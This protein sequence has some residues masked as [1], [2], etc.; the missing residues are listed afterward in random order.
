MANIPIHLQSL[1][2][3]VM[4]DLG[5]LHYNK[6]RMPVLRDAQRAASARAAA[7][8]LPPSD[9]DMAARQA[10]RDWRATQR[11]KSFADSDAIERGYITGRS[12]INTIGVRVVI[13]LKFGRRQP[14]GAKT[15]A[16]VLVNV[17]PGTTVAQ[18]VSAACDAWNARSLQT[19]HGFVSGSRCVGSGQIVQV[20]E[21][22]WSHSQVGV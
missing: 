2:S 7:I 13:N 19:P 10:I 12:T 5:E 3:A 22:G 21:G 4:H 1:A 17:R 8:G 16:T 15:T 11:V 9:A 20:I 6:G 18:A 14:P